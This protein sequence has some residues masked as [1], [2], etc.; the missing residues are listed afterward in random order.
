VIRRWRSRW[1][2]SDTY[3]PLL[4]QQLS[5]CIEI[6]ERCTQKEPGNRPIISHIIRDLNE[7]A[8]TNVYIPAANQVKLVYSRE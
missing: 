1:R 5:K 6:A 2:K 4:V 3:T 7:S 8:N